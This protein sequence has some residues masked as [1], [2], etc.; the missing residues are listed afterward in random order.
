MMMDGT[1]HLCKLETIIFLLPVQ[2]VT[3][4]FNFCSI[5]EHLNLILIMVLVYHT[6]FIKYQLF[7]FVYYF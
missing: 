2:F 1:L 6:I 7:C 4:N 5:L 3:I